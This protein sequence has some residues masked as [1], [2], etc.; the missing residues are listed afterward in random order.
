MKNPSAVFLEGRATGASGSVVVPVLEGT[1]PLL[2][3]IQALVS[4]TSYGPPRINAV[5]VESARVMMVLNVLEKRTGLKVA[6]MDV[7][8]NVAGGVRVNEPAA[9]LGIA[10]AIVSSF[11]DRAVPVDLVAFGE[12]GLT[13]ELRAVSM[14]VPRLQEAAKLGFE[15]AVTPKANA[16]EAKKSEVKT[17]VSGA[18]IL[19]AALES[20]FGPLH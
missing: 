12:L 8:V 16:A 18:D 11:L 2:V 3:E 1:R 15:R 20:V 9:D 19:P 4:P 7:F 17:V 6:G 14:G 13:G 10:T 5:G